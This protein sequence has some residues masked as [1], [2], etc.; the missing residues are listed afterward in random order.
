VL[1]LAAGTV[2]DADPVQ[3]VE[4]AAAAGFDACGLRLDPATSPAA[5]VRAVRSRLQDL[6]VAL[7][8]LEVVRM[9]PGRP[10]EEH[11][12]LLDLAGELGARWV[13]TVLEIPDRSE[14]ADRLARLDELA[15]DA[16]VR[17]SL[18]FMAFTAVRTFADASALCV[19][20]PRCRVLVDALHLARSGG[21]AADVAASADRLAYVQLCDGPAAVP[22]N[23]SPAALADE[24]RHHRLLPGSGALDLAGLI[25]ATPGYLARSV[26]VQSDELSTAMTVQERAVAAYRSVQPLIT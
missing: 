13:L 3:V 5:L 6:G 12:P 17:I 15:A 16:G 22:G 21:S 14:Q 23:G 24:A 1:S 20:L 10:A 26:E 19:G 9:Q 25:A 2:L 8:D 11:R 7:L 18:E 4:V